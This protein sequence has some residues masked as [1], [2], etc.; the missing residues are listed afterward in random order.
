MSFLKASLS[1]WLRVPLF[2]LLDR[3]NAQRKNNPARS[4]A[5]P[6]VAVDSAENTS[7][8]APSPSLEQDSTHAQPAVPGQETTTGR[9]R[10]P[11]APWHSAA[12]ILFR[13]AFVYF[14]LFCFC[15]G[16][17]TIFSIFP[18]IGNF[19]YRWLTWP[20]N[21]LAEWTGQHVFHLTGIGSHWHP[22]GSGDTTMNYLVDGL[23]VLAAV[24]GGLIWTLISELRGR[25]RE[26]RTLHAWLR[27][28][29][30]LTCGFF[31][32]NYGL[33]KLYP[34]QM[35]PVSI[36]ILNEPVGNMSPMTM[37]WALIG[38]NPVYEMICGAA[39]VIGGILLMFRRTALAGAL[40]SAFVITN[41]LL[42]NLFFDVPVKLFAANLLLAL[43]YLILPD[44]PP[45][46]NFF[47]RHRPSAPQADWAPPAHTKAARISL[48][49]TEIV[50]I[51][52]FLV[53]FPILM[54][55]G[56]FQSRKAAA[57][58]TPLLGA[59]HLD[60]DHPASGA[61]IT[62]EKQPVSDLYIDSAVRAF[63]RGPDGELWRTHLNIDPKAHT[64]HIRCYT[65]G[66]VNYAWSEPDPNHLVL[67]T[68]PPPAPKADSKKK[69]QKP[70]PAFTPE[71]L[72]LTRVPVPAHYPL[73][74][75]GFHWV[76]Q[77]GLE[78]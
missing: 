19:L 33:A 58:P 53:V 40:I 76:N 44:V 74:E 12:R 14:F 65:N 51:L 52:T 73:L 5:S 30:R 18:V 4:N 15:Y 36:A 37:L 64:V 21:T 9:E 32:L 75:R 2:I 28:A 6:R 29:L 55:M 11:E 25:R 16:N 66:E 62:P 22:T 3:P 10:I 61:F 13:V 43:V 78:R 46:W 7:P 31:M 59:W 48:R 57:V 38:L 54:G 56:F 26:Y 47:I 71:T 42:Y 24:A 68:V 72:T 41:V 39:E 20:F 60:A 49:I 34:M 77:W 17:G 63:M 27:F 70:A 45:L 8:S 50:F 69:D 67:T 35:A 1:T 23:F